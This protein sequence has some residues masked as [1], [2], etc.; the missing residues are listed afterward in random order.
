MSYWDTSTLGKLYFLKADSAA[1]ANKAG[2]TLII[3]TARLALHEMRRVAYRKE[4]DG[5]ISTDTAEVVLNQVDGGNGVENAGMPRKLRVRMTIRLTAPFMTPSGSLY[6]SERQEREQEK[7][8]RLVD[9]ELRRLGWTEKELAQRP[10]GDKQKV[11]TARML[12]QQTTM[13]LKWI[14]QRLHMSSWTYVFNFLHQDQHPN[15]N[16]ED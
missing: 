3:V 5:L 13:T 16:S 6:G 8:N 4:S 15:V 7:A 2:N 12:R 1:F 10:E 9:E 14:A 11:E